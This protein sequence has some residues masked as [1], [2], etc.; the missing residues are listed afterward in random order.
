MRQNRGPPVRCAAQD[1][2]QSDVVVPRLPLGPHPNPHFMNDEEAALGVPMH[3][4][5][6]AHCSKEDT[7]LDIPAYTNSGDLLER[8]SAVF[9]HLVKRDYGSNNALEKFR[10]QFLLFCTSQ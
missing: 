1:P 3:P 6:L 10:I 9:Y 7:W 4:I 2:I 5:R 8:H